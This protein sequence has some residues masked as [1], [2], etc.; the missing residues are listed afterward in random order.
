MPPESQITFCLPGIGADGID[1]DATAA[2]V[3]RLHGKLLTATSFH[4]VHKHAFDARFVKV[5]VLPK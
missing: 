2:Q 4:K 1:V 3:A 5:V